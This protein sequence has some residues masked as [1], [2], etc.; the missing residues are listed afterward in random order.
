[1]AQVLGGLSASSIQAL[2]ET[3]KGTLIR[4]DDDQYE[5]ARKVWNGAID[6]RPSLIARCRTNEDVVAAVNFARDNDVLFAVRGGGHS[7]P[8]I[9]TCD[10]GL[11]IDLAGMKQVEV[12]PGARTVTAQG[13]VTWGEFDAA[14]QAYGLAVTGGHV[15]HTGIAGLTT[16]SGIGHLMRNLGL[17]S[18]NLLSAE[19]VL[20]DGRVV[21][22]SESENS[23]LFWGIRGGGGNFGVVTSFTYRLHELPGPVLAGLVF[24]DARQGPEFLR[25]Y[26]E[27]AD[28]LP[29][30]I[31]TI[32]AHLCAPPFPFVPPEVLGQPGYAVVMVCQG[33]IEAAGKTIQPAREFGPPLFEMVAPMPYVA[34]QQLFDPA[35]PPGTKAY[36]KTNDRMAYTDACIETIVENC[37][38]MKPGHSQVLLFQLGGALTRLP[39]DATAYANRSA[40]YMDAYIAIW[41]DD[42]EKDEVIAWSRRFHEEMKP[43]SRGSFN[44]SFAGDDE[45]PDIVAQAY[46]PE[47][48]AR[49]QALKTK[50][51][52]QNLFRLNQNIKPA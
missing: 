5:Q 16:G 12:D 10:D 30:E 3:F 35:L 46:G 27:W 31:T 2:R 41:E 29:D 43:H 22:A 48:Y 21:T 37:A 36:L 28:T 26:R 40:K 15:T 44:P 50:Y 8:G 38:R 39:D 49:L 33:S 32:A 25:F 45:P 17:T 51:D 42:A 18:D 14:T 6:K 7:F 11:V 23:D 4:P 1:M 19:V 47:K 13:G 24:Y 9:S 20:A 52:P 34:V